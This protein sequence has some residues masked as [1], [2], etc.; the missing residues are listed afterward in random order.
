MTYMSAKPFRLANPALPTIRISPPNPLYVNTITGSSVGTGSISNPVNSLALAMSLCAGLPDWQI[1]VTAPSTNPLRQE[2][3]YNS[4]FDLMIDGKDGEPWY[5]YGSDALDNSWIGSGPVYSKVL[6]YTLVTQ[7]VIT[8]MTEMIGDKLFPIKLVQNTTTPTTPLAGEFG[9]TGGIMYIRLPDSSNPILQNIE[10]ARRNTCLSTIGSGFLKLNNLQAEH[11]LV[12]CVN[13][14][15]FG[16]PLGT[17][18]LEITNSL[19]R[20]AGNGGV[21]AAGQNEITIARNVTCERI[22]ND[23]FNHHVLS[24]TGV[25][26]LYSCSGSYNGI[27]AGQSAQGASNHENSVMNIYGGN[28][29]YNVSGGMVV[30]ETA[31]CNLYGNTVDGP[32]LMD[33]NMRLGNTPGPVSSQAGCAWLDSSSGIVT[34]GVTVSNGLGV[35]VRKSSTATVIGINNILS[36]NNALPDIIV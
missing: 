19:C 28:Y 21:G 8:T 22:D 15:L 36:V 18:K 27:K 25:M 14:G 3:L 35:G 32:I 31:T 20:F 4:S 5:N 13:N 16:Q 10:V 29:N 11:A 24:G 26:D 23:G 34:T 6:N 12:N 2:N 33:R 17:G 1:L 9:Y 7:V 30:I